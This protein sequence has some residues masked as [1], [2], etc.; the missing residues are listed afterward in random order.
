MSQKGIEQLVGRALA[1]KKFLED[2]MKD[3]EGKIKQSGFDIS[4]QE[5]EQIKKVDSGKARQFAERFSSEFTSRQ[6][7]CA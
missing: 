1:D 7:G 6:Q 5:L 3:P 2:L 4:V